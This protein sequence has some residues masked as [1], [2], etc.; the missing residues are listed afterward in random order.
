MWLRSARKRKKARVRWVHV[1]SGD[2]VEEGGRVVSGIAGISE[3]LYN[4]IIGMD[5]SML[6][7]PDGKFI[8]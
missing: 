7:A 6:R 3:A 1:R 8:I 4:F 5:L 2:R